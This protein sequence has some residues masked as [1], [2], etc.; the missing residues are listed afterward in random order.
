M[1]T[2]HLGKKIDL[3]TITDD[4]LL[5]GKQSTI[6]KKWDQFH[7]DY[8]SQVGDA[9]GFRRTTSNKDKLSKD[10]RKTFERIYEEYNK[11]K[12]L[13]EVFGSYNNLFNCLFAKSYGFE[14]EQ[15]EYGEWLFEDKLSSLEQELIN[16]RNL[17]QEKKTKER[18]K[19]INELK[20]NIKL[21]RFTRNINLPRLLYLSLQNFEKK[22]KNTFSDSIRISYSLKDT[23]EAILT[24]EISDNLW[25]NIFAGSNDCIFI[26]AAKSDTEVKQFT[27][28]K[29][30]YGSLLHGYHP[31]IHYLDFKTK[32]K[33]IADPLFRVKLMDAVDEHG[34][35]YLVLGGVL[36]E[37]FDNVKTDKTD[38]K[39]F[40]DKV[41]I[42]YF[43][44][45][46]KKND[47]LF[48]N[49]MH[50]YNP[51][52]PYNQFTDYIK[53]KYSINESK[54]EPIAEKDGVRFNHKLK[55]QSAIEEID[56]I[57][58]I[59][60]EGKSKYKGEQ[61]S[62]T[63]EKNKD[64]SVPGAFVSLEGLVYGFEV[65]YNN[66]K[67]KKKK[68]RIWPYIAAGLLAV[69]IAGLTTYLTVTGKNIRIGLLNYGSNSNS[70]G[71]V[72][73]DVVNVHEP[74]KK[75][76]SKKRDSEKLEEKAII[77]INYEFLYKGNLVTYSDEEIVQRTF[78]ILTKLCD[79]NKSSY[80]NAGD[81]FLYYCKTSDDG[82]C[83]ILDQNNSETIFV[84]DKYRKRIDKSIVDV[85]GYVVNNKPSFIFEMNTE[86]IIFKTEIIKQTVL[87][88]GIL[89]YSQS[90]KMMFKDIDR[91]LEIFFSSEHAFSNREFPK[92]NGLLATQIMKYTLNA[93]KRLDI[94]KEGS[95]IENS[96]R[97]SNY[98][99]DLEIYFDTGKTLILPLNKENSYVVRTILDIINKNKIFEAEVYYNQKLLTLE[100]T[101]K[102]YFLQGT[103]EDSYDKARAIVV[104]ATNLFRT[105]VTRRDERLTKTKELRDSLIDKVNNYNNLHSLNQLDLSHLLDN[106]QDEEI[107]RKTID[108]V[109]EYSATNYVPVLLREIANITDYN[110]IIHRLKLDDFFI[111]Y[112]DN[113]KVKD[114]LKKEPNFL[115]LIH[116]IMHTYA[117]I[118]PISQ[119]QK[120]SSLFQFVELYKNNMNI[121][122]NKK[123]NVVNNLLQC[124]RRFYSSCNEGLNEYFEIVEYAASKGEFGCQ[125]EGDIKGSHL[126]KST[127][128][129]IGGS[130]LIDL[131]IGDVSNLVKTL[132]TEILMKCPPCNNVLKNSR[133]VVISEHD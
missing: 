46:Y 101:R 21:I 9:V 29:F 111:V 119:E 102:K 10:E 96:D 129:Y 108:I 97:I 124:V 80:K 61:Y 72:N 84:V 44:K 66:L 4:C 42:D 45:N 71:Q 130:C 79:P 98:E 110:P 57:S 24:A 76:G 100:K 23:I 109:N 99:F 37:S 43:L 120:I 30:W 59:D 88:L 89:H 14:Y 69:G 50:V 64:D 31:K 132:L 85:N 20:E 81:C 3:E 53:D 56:L 104:E 63:F 83:E 68:R 91:L 131:S 112:L 39:K 19:K 48:Y 65:D 35:K 87:E 94:L 82:L 103:K 128:E 12:F 127:M 40:I 6:Q 118:K 74:K 122:D 117:F 52:K 8:I 18:E 27:L 33:G 1:I 78:P 70:N 115:E 17:Y 16:E 28:E 77:K 36:G 13:Q 38:I 67:F 32:S 49:F 34:K 95:K 54:L 26:N 75:D 25:G 47:A 93:R 5:K 126:L 7:I 125:K 55:V 58:T 107:L 51:Q 11:E 15:S 116:I 60:T 114:F 86:K 22:N 123:D 106:V 2:D 41:I 133:K 105:L 73:I 90:P 113:N 121:S 92:L 62:E